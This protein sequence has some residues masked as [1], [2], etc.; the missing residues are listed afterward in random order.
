VIVLGALCAG[1]ALWWSAEL[2]FGPR[3]DRP[4]RD[5][6]RRTARVGAN[7]RPSRQ[8]WL[9]Q[10]GAAVTPGQFWTVSAAL[11]VVTFLAVLVLDRTPVVALMP[12]LAAATAPLGYWSGQRRKRTAA[13]LAAWPEALRQVS[14]RLQSGISTLHEALEEVSRSGPPP[15]RAPMA[16]YVRLANRIGQGAALEAVRFELAD[17]VSDPIILT[18][19]MAVAEGTEQVLRILTD[20]TSQIEGDLQLA[21]RITTLQTQSRIATWAVFA[22]P[23]ALLVF[24]CAT[25]S[26]YRSFF[27]EPVGLAVMFCGIGLSVTGLW[28]ARR[29]GR[30][31]PTTQRVFAVGRQTV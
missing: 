3:R 24:L 10:A 9:S 4:R 30:S 31:I 22:V 27:S 17:P 12:A 28:I 15:L 21:D 19:E 18:F 5:R 20:L 6:P 16:R 11:G 2:V 14:G 25:Q 29:L 7:R 23:Y 26:F 8:I 1:G 13:R